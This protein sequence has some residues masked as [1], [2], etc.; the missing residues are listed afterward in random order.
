VHVNYKSKGGIKMVT[1]VEKMLDDYNTAWSSYDVEKIALFFTDDCV[2]ED[3]AMGVVNR[4]KHELKAFLA[5]TFATF[6][7][8]KIEPNSILS[9]G[10]RVATEWVMTGTQKGGLPGIPATGKSFSVRGV[11][12]VELRAGKIRRKSDYWNQAA[13]LQQLGVMPAAPPSG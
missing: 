9:D 3:V 11:S 7:D 8:F 10:E 13:L 5:G 12:I 2:Y 4:G 1:D 6:P